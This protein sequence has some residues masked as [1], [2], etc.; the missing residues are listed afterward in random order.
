MP[1]NFTEIHFLNDHFILIFHT[2]TLLPP[3]SHS[4]TEYWLNANR[5][6]GPLWVPS[7]I[8][9]LVVYKKGV[10]V[11]QI[12]ELLPIDLK[13]KVQQLFISTNPKLNSTVLQTEFVLHLNLLCDC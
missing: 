11:S 4:A 13:K 10:F 5:N 2:I 3:Q 9:L 1:D 7:P 12:D 8:F 6:L